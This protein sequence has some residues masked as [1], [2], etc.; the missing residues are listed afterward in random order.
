MGE[1]V[2]REPASVAGDVAGMGRVMRALFAAPAGAGQAPPPAGR[3]WRR[4]DLPDEL[5]AVVER[6]M[7]LRPGERFADVDA[8]MRALET[9]WRCPVKGPAAR[10]GAV[11][12]GGVRVEAQPAVAEHVDAF[13]GA[14][15]VV[16]GPRP[17]ALRAEG[18][19]RAAAA[20]AAVDLEEATTFAPRRTDAV[21]PVPERERTGV[22]STA[23]GAESAAAPV[24]EGTMLALHR[25][26]AEYVPAE[27]D[28]VFATHGGGEAASS[29][30]LSETVVVSAA[31][32]P[33]SPWDAPGLVIAETE[34]VGRGGAGG[35]GRGRP[36]TVAMGS[37]NPW[38]TEVRQRE[39]S[40]PGGLRAERGGASRGWR[41]AAAVVAVVAAGVM[42]VL[43]LAR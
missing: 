19:A 22:L 34:V 41:V 36:P 17:G 20:G 40:V 9:A 10:P 1:A 37:S 11:V 25:Q 31:E 3:D 29:G 27:G 33:R 8:L 26:G 4:D 16:L 24:D 28:T 12:G 18:A 21:Q 15:E 5:W 2:G 42:V 13:D 7:A 14:T 23:W 32:L 6:A 35:G 30:V 43:L 39:V 38:A